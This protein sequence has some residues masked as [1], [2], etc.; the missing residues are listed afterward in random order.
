MFSVRTV[1]VYVG[2]SPS[3]EDEAIEGEEKVIGTGY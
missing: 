3:W 2:W 1:G